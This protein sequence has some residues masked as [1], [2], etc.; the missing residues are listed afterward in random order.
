VRAVCDPIEEGHALWRPY[1]TRH[2][3]NYAWQYHNGGIW[4]LIG[5]FYAAALAETGLAGEARSAL[6]GLARMNALRDWSFHEW[7]HGRTHRPC[8][9][10]GQS[11]NAAAFLLAR[12]ALA[13]GGRLLGAPLPR[14][15]GQALAG[16]ATMSR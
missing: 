7:L 2:R 14:T 12:H 1:M 3:Q 5:G 11:W 6:A 9:M 13:A 8:G 10:R 15:R 4:G 16:D